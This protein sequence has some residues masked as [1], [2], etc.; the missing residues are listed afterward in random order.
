MEVRNGTSIILGAIKK[1][2]VQCF[3]IQDRIHD[4]ILDDARKIGPQTVLTENWFSGKSETGWTIS[5]TFFEYIANGVHSWFI[6][7]NAQWP[8]MLFADGHKSH[9][10]LE[11]GKICEENGIILYTVP[12]CGW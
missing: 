4:R 2:G 10:T 11:L 6:E 3:S 1:Y 9:M 8:I 7:H 5:E 12:A